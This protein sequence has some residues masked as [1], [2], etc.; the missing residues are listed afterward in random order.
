MDKP[1]QTPSTDIRIGYFSAIIGFWTIRQF[2]VASGDAANGASSRDTSYCNG[3]N[4]GSARL[5]YD[6][7]FAARHVFSFAT[8]LVATNFRRDKTVVKASNYRSHA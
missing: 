8:Q 1:L 5:D 4:D 7:R 3:L 2:V 6:P